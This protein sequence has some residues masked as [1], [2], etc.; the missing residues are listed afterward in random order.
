MIR[1][2]RSKKVDDNLFELRGHQV[3]VFYMF[4]PGRRIVLL[5]GIIKK[6]DEIPKR[7]LQRVR[8]YKREVEGSR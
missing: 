4:L 2:P 7:D 6:T 1:P 5:D 3:R 8:Q